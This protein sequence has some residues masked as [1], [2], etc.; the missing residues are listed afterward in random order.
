MKAAPNPFRYCNS[1]PDVI[2]L[3][4]MTDV[5][6]ALEQQIFHGA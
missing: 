2:R 1:S 5:D 3:V 6:P 4:V